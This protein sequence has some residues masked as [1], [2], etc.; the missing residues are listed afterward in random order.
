MP[1]KKSRTYT[2]VEL[3]FMHIVWELGEPTP[4]DIEASLRAGGRSISIGSIR[5]VLAIMME[6]GYLTR[7]KEGKAFRYRAQA[8]REQAGKVALAELVSTLFGGSESLV[9][10]AL[11]DNRSL[12]TDERE[13]IRLL[14]GDS[15]G[16]H[17][18]ES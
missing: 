3:E 8:Q 2:E 16:G 13:R 7:R 17:R 6:K 9:V 15:G 10:A 4:D 12:S 18:D 11:L 5:N 1:R 14:I